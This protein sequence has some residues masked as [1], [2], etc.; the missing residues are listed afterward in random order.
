MEEQ[1]ELAS[2]R[3]WTVDKFSAH[4]HSIYFLQALQPAGCT[5][6]PESELAKLNDKKLPG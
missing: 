6:T 4:E 5:G 1:E 3:G 2:L